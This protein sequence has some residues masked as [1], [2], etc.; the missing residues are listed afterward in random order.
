MNI[1]SLKE[2]S[3]T[4]QQLA[5][6]Q[7]FREAVEN[8]ETALNQWYT[9]PSL[10]T[11]IVS[12][13]GA[14]NLIHSLE[15]QVVEW[16]TQIEKADKLINQA[17]LILNQDTGDPF[18]ITSIT[19]AI[20]IYHL[21]RQV[22][23]EPKI[24]EL[25]T[26]YQ[27]EVAQR[28][29]FQSLVKQ[30]QT[31]AKNYFLKSAIS[32]YKEASYLYN[33]EHLN[34]TI[35]DIQCQVYQEDNYHSAL[36]KARNAEGE[37]K[38]KFAISILEEA[39]VSFPRS[40]GF[41]LLKK[42]K[43][44]VKGKE[45]FAHGLVAEKKGNFSSAKS[46]YEQAQSLISNPSDCQ[47]RLGIL[48][49]KQQNWENAQSY[50]HNLP[51]QQANYLRGF[52]FAQQGDL[53]SAYQ[54]WEK[55][56]HPLV[57]KQKEIL[58][59]IYQ[60][61]NLIHIQ[62]IENLV[63]EADFT[64]A[65]NTS[66]QLLQTFPS[67]S[68][69]ENNLKKYIEPTIEKSIWQSYDW[70]KIFDYTQENWIKNPN[71][72]TLHNWVVANYYY[73]QTNPEKL[74]ILIIALSTA[75]ANLTMDNSL[76]NLPWLQDQKVDFTTLSVN[77]KLRLEAAIDQV[78]NTDIE[79]YFSLRDYYR[80]ESVAL[81]FMGEPSHS[82]MQV[83]NLFIT[84][85]CYDHFSQQWQTLLTDNIPN[86]C[87]TL[88]SLYT[89]WGLAVAACLEGDSQR[90]IK[91]KPKHEPTHKSEIFAD[92]ILN[93]YEGCYHLQQ[94]RWHLAMK[95]L[96]SIQAEI[97][98]H[99]DWQEKIARLLNLQRQGILE[100]N[101]HLEFANF[102]Y[103]ILPKNLFVK[104]YYTEY[105]AEEIRQKIVNDQIS[106]NQSLEKLQELQVIDRHNPVVLDMIDNVELS[107]E[108]KEI[109]R[110]FHVH[111]YEA[112]LK[113]AKLSKRDRVRYIVAEFF[114]N[115]IIK[116]VQEN[117][118]HDQELILQLGTWAYEICPHEPAFQEIYRSLKLC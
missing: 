4:S 48:A 18:N 3:Q 111:Q 105:K 115:L 106:L 49:I 44:R 101:E 112:M 55:I 20:A 102:C 12:K 89:P 54:E 94:Q 86:D 108:I 24:S 6:Q 46:C 116:G 104:S 64:A 68:W 28:Q 11:K 58:A 41:N 82:G 57:A 117:R 98:Y 65:R 60:Q 33:H 88:R 51:G 29:K 100:F 7:K 13:F 63:T 80:R 14:T 37:N 61:Q 5:Q 39:L 34:D 97:I 53:Q 40:D 43:I 72:D 70:A 91:I 79:T 95:P 103:E 30:A 8:A 19:S 27:Q 35:S 92:Q 66:K 109:N 110:L 38:L 2:A 73:S 118:L 42:L 93:Y 113:K 47:I 22:I 114:L 83:N 45:I 52:I 36:E 90:G 78:K 56:S 81:K 50:L 85:G 67:H 62:E 1:D 74:D 96:Q 17:E 23:F 10:W 31:Q 69:I 9:T 32:I 25:I 77:L 75:L 87:I 16:R 59:H 76:K 99:P 107:Q 21:A 15:Q 71:I 84:P 26:Q